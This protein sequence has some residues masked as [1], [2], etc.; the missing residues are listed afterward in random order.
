VEERRREVRVDREEPVGGLDEVPATHA[1]AFL[2]EPTLV[3]QGADV[4]DHGVAE[5]D[6]ELAVAERQ[7]EPIADQPRQAVP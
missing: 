6:V 1:T 4:L 7:P 3:L 5:H 2:G